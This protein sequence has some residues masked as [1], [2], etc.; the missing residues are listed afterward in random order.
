MTDQWIA[1]EIDEADPGLEWLINEAWAIDG[2]LRDH[3]F[4]INDGEAATC[5]CKFEGQQP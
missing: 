3:Y 5:G 4:H 1:P 2:D